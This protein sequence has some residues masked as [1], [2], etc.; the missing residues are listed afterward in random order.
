MGKTLQF[1]AFRDLWSDKNASRVQVIVTWSSITNEL[2]A[3]EP[4]FCGAF[5][6][7][8]ILRLP[9]LPNMPNLIM[10][11]LP[12]R[13]QLRKV[14]VIL[15]RCRIAILHPEPA[16]RSLSRGAPTHLVPA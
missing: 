10:K 4:A 16:C 3:F 15:T 6:S 13:A 1:T 5:E 8:Q 9:E 7:P 11:A 14:D 2:K 12:W